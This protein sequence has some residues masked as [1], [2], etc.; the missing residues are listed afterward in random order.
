MLQVRA[1][2]CPGCKEEAPPG[3]EYCSI[4]GEYLGW[5]T[6]S[7]QHIPR[8]KTTARRRST[9]QSVVRLL[10]F[11]LAAYLFSLLA[12]RVFNAPSNSITEIPPLQSTPAPSGNAL[13]DNAATDDAFG[14][15]TSDN[16]TSDNAPNGNSASVNSVSDNS[17]SNSA[18]TP[19]AGNELSDLE[20]P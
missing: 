3:A 4:C 18:S 14:N 6:T 15:A 19:A 8:H 7:G 13:N 10:T 2:R 11:F 5:Q 17:V 16:A 9:A 12:I 1:G 20:L